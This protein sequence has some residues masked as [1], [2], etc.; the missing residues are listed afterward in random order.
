MLSEYWTHCHNYPHGIT[1]N[2]DL[3]DQLSAILIHLIVGTS[4]V[5]P[6]KSKVIVV[7]IDVSASGESST[8]PFDHD[9]LCQWLDMIDGMKSMYRR[10]KITII[11]IPAGLAASPDAQPHI[12]TAFCPSDLF[13]CHFLPYLMLP[14]YTV[15]PG[16]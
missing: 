10:I 9:D 2:D 11:L 15:Q 13:S 3:F 12:V 1:L 5:R 14:R 8:N 16:S 6:E 4:S 7:L